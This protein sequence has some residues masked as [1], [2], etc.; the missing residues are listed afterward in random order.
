MSN[1]A[2]KI[3]SRLKYDKTG[4]NSPLKKFVI[5]AI[6]RSGSN[7][8]CGA[9]NSH[10]EILCHHEVFHGKKI[11][12]DNQL[13][14]GTVEQRDRAPKQFIDHLWRQ[15]MGFTAVGFK[16]LWGQNPKAF[17][18]LTRDKNVKKILLLRRN[19]LKSYVSYLVAQETGVWAQRNTELE[20]KKKEVKQ[21]S[22]S[23]EI[24]SLHKYIIKVD[25]YYDKLRKN[26]RNSRQ[27][28][29]EI[30][31]EDILGNNSEEAKSKILEFIGVS[32]NHQCLQTKTKKQNS[33]ELCN[34]ISNFTELES[35]LRETE[36]EHYLYSDT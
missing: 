15:N 19:K 2:T 13:N 21:M 23:V 35:N 27:S 16:L 17:K 25:K 14:L 1:L 22:V 26:I 32:E 20:A 3:L 30:Y 33:N 8:L 9:L 31:Y 5:F 11:Y 18:I 29:I 24:D 28:F 6:P 4:V 7:Y 12:G 34:L 36:L 10:P